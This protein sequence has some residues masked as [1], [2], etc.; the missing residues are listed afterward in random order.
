[1]AGKIKIRP[2]TWGSKSYKQVL[3][4]RNEILNKPS[5][6]P[7]IES[8]PK[9][10]KKFI[11]LAAYHKNEI[12]GT[13]SIDRLS[14][15]AVQIRQVAISSKLQGHGIGKKLMTSAEKIAKFFRFKKIVLDARDNAWSFYEKLGYYPRSDKEMYKNED[16]YMKPYEKD[17]ELAVFKFNHRNVMF[18]YLMDRKMKNMLNPIEEDQTI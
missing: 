6:L 14:S 10:E 12:V 3:E 7:L 2:I 8:M 11:I 15:D 13:L 9:N 16:L 18:Y 4:L 17:I 5:N 1:M